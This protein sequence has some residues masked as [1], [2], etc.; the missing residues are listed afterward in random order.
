[1]LNHPWFCLLDETHTVSY[2]QW[3][4]HHHIVRV[5]RFLSCIPTDDRCVSTILFGQGI[6]AKNLPQK[7][8]RLDDIMR[9][10]RDFSPLS[11]KPEL[12]L[13]LARQWWTFTDGLYLLYQCIWMLVLL[14]THQRLT[15]RKAP[16]DSHGICH[17]GSVPWSAPPDFTWASRRRDGERSLFSCK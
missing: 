1:M 8:I 10:F 9:Y 13:T 6:L 16:M 5:S 15:V 2:R 7:H 4:K 3:S 12:P 14:T 17:F 11:K